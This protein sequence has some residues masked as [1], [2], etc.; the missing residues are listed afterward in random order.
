MTNISGSDS[1]DKVVSGYKNI[2]GCEYKNKI[3]YL[4]YPDIKS[5]YPF[6]KNTTDDIEKAWNIF[7][8]NKNDV[9]DIYSNCEELFLVTDFY[10]VLPK[11]FLKFERLKK[12]T[13]N[14]LRWFGLNCRQIPV[15]I[16]Y[17]D[18]YSQN[19]PRNALDGIDRMKELRTLILPYNAFY[20]SQVENDTTQ[21]DMVP[22]YDL[23]YLSEIRIIIKLLSDSDENS[24]DKYKNIISNGKLLDNIRY[25]MKLMQYNR[26]KFNNIDYI[27]I[28][29]ERKYNNVK[30]NC[31]NVRNYNTKQYD[32]EQNHLEQNHLEHNDTE[33]NDTEQYKIKNIRRYGQKYDIDMI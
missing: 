15:T 4:L 14:G 12:I 20:D 16:E 8:D 29:L 24:I 30:K 25:R 6:M 23:E 33:H 2:F 5:C 3:L 11:V 9:Y 31:G 22:I 21:F 19:L 32:V 17:L 7:I 26:D 1:K 18:L 27:D 13:V 10:F 28:H